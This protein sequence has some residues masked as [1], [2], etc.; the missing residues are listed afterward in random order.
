MVWIVAMRFA[1]SVIDDEHCH[2]DQYASLKASWQVVPGANSAGRVRG[3]SVI[4]RL[5]A[6]PCC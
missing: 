6:A 5:E 3:R 2:P 4:P 1:N